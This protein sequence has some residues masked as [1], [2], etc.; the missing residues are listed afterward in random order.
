MLFGNIWG[1][2][3]CGAAAEGLKREMDGSASSQFLSLVELLLRN[4]SNC[5]VSAPPPSSLF[6]SLSLIG[7]FIKSPISHLWGF[8]VARKH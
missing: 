3:D 8:Y 6:L 1:E 4:F 2:K 5:K 7:C